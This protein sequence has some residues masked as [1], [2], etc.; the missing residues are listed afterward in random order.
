MIEIYLSN[1]QEIN[2]KMVTKLEQIDQIVPDCWIN[3]SAPTE[4]EL[5]YVET[6]LDIPS[7]F[8]RYPLDEEERPRIDF[9]MTTV[10]F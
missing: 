3:L 4:D 8:L 5:E 6:T 10:R 2:G 9:G 1:T 7:E